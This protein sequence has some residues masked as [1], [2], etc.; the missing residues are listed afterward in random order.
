MEMGRLSPL[1]PAV[2]ARGGEQ[3]QDRKQ[4]ELSRGCKHDGLRAGPVRDLP[5]S[6]QVFLAWGLLALQAT[7]GLGFVAAPL[8]RP[9][10]WRFNVD[11]Y[12]CRTAE[13]LTSA[14]V[15]GFGGAGGGDS[16][17]KCAK[18]QLL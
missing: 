17:A 14:Q 1:S 18:T 6:H 11:M 12:F 5:G 9:S 16:L 2:I 3:F 4:M 8:R 7:C 13:M 15:C 10:A